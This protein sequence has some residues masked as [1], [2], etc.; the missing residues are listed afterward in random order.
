METRRPDDKPSVRTFLI[1]DVRGYTRFTREHGDA[2]AAR[3]ATRFADLARDAVEA[4]RGHVIELRGDEALAVFESTAQAVRAAVEFQAICSEDTAADPSLPLT[5]GIGIDVGEAIPVEDGFRGVALNTAARL[6]SRAL[7]GQI[8][9]TRSVADGAA[10]VDDVALEEIGPAELKGFDTPVEVI[11]VVA[12]RP[13]LADVRRIPPSFVPPELE[14]LTPLVGREREMHWLRG[15]WRQAR[16]G[17]GRIVFL[18]GPSQIGKTRLASEL[19]AT[20]AD[21]GERVAYAGA[22]GAATALAVAAI[23]EATRADE[24]MLLVLDD[25]D[26]AGEDGA[27]AL[28]D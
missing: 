22:G 12:T 25:L 18:S 15:T 8:L 10:D 4:R 11:A 26:V 16:R 5:V 6:C 19:A 17:R 28:A 3:L 1:A 27:R 9:V 13:P 20:V 23:R 14:A 2:A 7:A 24:P 21:E